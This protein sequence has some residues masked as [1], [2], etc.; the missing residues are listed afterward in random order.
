MHYKLHK[1][2]SFLRIWSHLL[3]KSLMENFI[4]CA[5]WF[6]SKNLCK[7]Q[8]KT[9]VSDLFFNKKSRIVQKELQHKCFPLNFIKFV[10]AVILGTIHIWHPW[11]LSN[12]QDPPPFCSATSEILPPLDL[13]R[14]ISNIPPLLSKWWPI[15]QKEGQRS[16]F[17]FSINSLILPSFPWT[18][19]HLVE[20]NLFPRATLK[21]LNSLFRLPH[22]AKRRTGFKVDLKPHCLLFSGFTI[23]LKQLSK[24]ITKYFLKKSFF[25][26]HFSVNLFYLHNLKT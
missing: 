8:R 13:G 14:P 7:T 23:L 10:R 11:K 17:V 22:I 4:F 26:A 5:A 18:S 6:C 16:A 12:I 1:K 25:S 2:W 20:A 9:S 3:K 21:N 24:N 15:N 19:F